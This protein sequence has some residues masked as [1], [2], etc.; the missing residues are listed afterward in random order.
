MI[1][2][3]AYKGDIEEFCENEELRKAQ[4]KIKQ[5]EQEGSVKLLKIKQLEQ[6]VEALKLRRE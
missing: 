2:I 6:E 1:K 3:I 4:E 5:L